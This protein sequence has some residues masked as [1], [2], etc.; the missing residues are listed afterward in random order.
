MPR[1]EAENRGSRAQGRR[2][3]R[4]RS[5]SAALDTAL[6]RV[7]LFLCDVDGVL[8]DGSVLIGGEQEIK[9]FNIRDGLGLVRLRGAGLKA[10][11]VSSRPSAATTRRAR[12]LKIDFLSQEIGR[13]SCR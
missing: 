2:P 3:A 13:A 8:T 12:E 9:R 7:R 5:G 6:K 10:G 11:W 1:T 4:G